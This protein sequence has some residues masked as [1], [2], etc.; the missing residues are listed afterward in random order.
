MS[1]LPKKETTALSFYNGNKSTEQQ[2]MY[3][4]VKY[5]PLY[6][7]VDERVLLVGK[8]NLI[9]REVQHEVAVLIYNLFMHEHHHSHNHP[10]TSPYLPPEHRFLRHR[11]FYIWCLNQF[12]HWW[13]TSRLLVRLAGGYVYCLDPLLWATMA[14]WDVQDP[15]E[16]KL[17]WKQSKAIGQGGTIK[18]FLEDVHPFTRSIRIILAVARAWE[19]RVDNRLYEVGLAEAL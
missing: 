5:P 1:L 11:N 9:P 19:A 16:A 12:R 6:G 10:K 13:K 14:M 2:H 17:A 15:T 4:D 8:P 18:P 3:E 7:S